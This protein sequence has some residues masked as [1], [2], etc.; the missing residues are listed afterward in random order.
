MSTD[1]NY[2]GPDICDSVVEKGEKSTSLE[3]TEN[4]ASESDHVFAT[5]VENHNSIDCSAGSKHLSQDHSGT[6]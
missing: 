5:D 1:H 4:S 3:P 6:V 2:A